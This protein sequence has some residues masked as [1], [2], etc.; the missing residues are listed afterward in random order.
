MRIPIMIFLILFYSTGCFAD[1]HNEKIQTLMKAQGLVQTF[2][3]Q[4]QLGKEYARKQAQQILNQ[5]MSDLNP[6]PEYK[7]KFRSA[8]DEFI[9]EMEAPWSGKDIVDVWAKIYGQRFT[10]D[11]LDQLIVFYSSPLEQKD[12]VASRESLP[13]FNKHFVELSKPII[14]HATKNYI[15]HLKAIAKK[16]DCNK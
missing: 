13:E 14:E 6:T 1:D 4:L 10:D 5:I 7:A 12:V 2:D 16:C 9:R 11:E 8:S 3:R 15:Q